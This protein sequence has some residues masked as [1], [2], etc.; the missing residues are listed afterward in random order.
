MELAHARLW[1]QQS[2]NDAALGSAAAAGGGVAAA[3][4]ATAA[5]S[6]ASTA[7][8]ANDLPVGVELRPDSA[9]DWD[10]RGSQDG[11]DALAEV[12]AMAARK[13]KMKGRNQE[14]VALETAT[15][16]QVRVR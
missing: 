13:A 6:P 1:P 14:A 10:A 4:P 16:M 11:A 8:D 2:R 12:Q 3:A 15:A 9:M 5:A 7:A